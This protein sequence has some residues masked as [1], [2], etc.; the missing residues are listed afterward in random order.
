MGLKNSLRNTQAVLL[1]SV[2][3]SGCG[4][5]AATT[6]TPTGAATLQTSAAVAATPSPFTSTAA[7]QASAA[8]APAPT[9]TPQSQSANPTPTA[10]GSVQA[11]G[12]AT[13]HW[14]APQYNENGSKLTDLAGYRIHYG[15]DQK[16]LQKIVSVG[17]QIHDVQIEELSPGIWYFAVVAVNK[18]GIESEMSDIKWKK[19][20]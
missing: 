1:F 14:E 10:G 6:T 13:V 19:I 4:G 18:A 9:A 17:P 3:L 20:G 5:G 11:K 12:V 15:L 16:D 7:P 2:I 8:A